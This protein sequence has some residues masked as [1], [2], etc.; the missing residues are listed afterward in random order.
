[1][2]PLLVGFFRVAIAAPCLCL[3]A[4]WLGGPHPG[5]DRGDRG[6]LLV[7][8]VAMGAFQ[9]FYFWG[10]AKTS[11][12]VGSLVA[13]CS[14]PALH[15]GP[16]RRCCS[17]SASTAGPGPLCW[18][19]SRAPR[20]SRSGP[21]GSAASAG[22]PGRR[23]AGARRRA[24]VRHLRGDGEGRR[25]SRGA[26]DRRRADLLD[27]G[28]HAPPACSSWSGRWPTR[29]AWALLAYLGVVPTAVAYVLYVLGL[30]TTRVAVSGVLT[31]VGAPDGDAPRRPVLRGPARARSARSAP[32]LLLSAVLG[33]TTRR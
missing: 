11:V 29:A 3:A 7:A 19:G 16:G 5:A 15:H 4:R 30:R 12:A 1:M 26:A 20:C 2:S 24:L 28:A 23:G 14:A 22:L 21:T 18:P 25:P 17:G 13:I 10:V 31:L 33:L 8:G 6:R 27:R 9:A 32:A